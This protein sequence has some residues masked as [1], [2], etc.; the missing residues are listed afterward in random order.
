[1]RRY[2]T[3]KENWLL[4]GIVAEQFPLSVEVAIVSLSPESL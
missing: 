4:L 3:E 2:E 1:M